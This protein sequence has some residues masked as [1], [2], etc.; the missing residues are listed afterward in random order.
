MERQRRAN[1]PENYDEKRRI[2]KHGKS[3]LRWKE[4]KRYQA[5]RRQHANAER[6]LAAHRKSLH[7]KLAHDIVRIGNTIRIEKTSFKGWQKQYGRSIGLRAPGMWVE[8]VRRL[9]AKTGGTLSEISAFQT[10]LSQYCHGCQTYVKKSR[11]Q[12]WHTCPCGIGPVQ[13]DLY[14]AFLL[15]SLEPENTIPS[16]TQSDWEGA[17][18]RLYAVMEGLRQ[19]ANDGHCLPRSMGLSAAHSATRA[20]A[21]RQKSPAKPH[22]ELALLLGRQEAVGVEQEPPCL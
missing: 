19:R 17:E 9:V 3:R 11:A 18:P 14:S 22:Q 8:H 13:R 2:K 7:G 21:R 12:R 6:K 5:T 20:R 10:K 1:N 16:L 4:S 15:A